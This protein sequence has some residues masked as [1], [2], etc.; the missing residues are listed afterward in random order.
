MLTQINNWLTA[1]TTALDADADLA[2]VV[3]HLGPLVT[4]DDI[5]GAALVIVGHDDDDESGMA[6]E[7]TG[8]W[9]D[10]G[11]A[12]IHRGDA[13]V[14]ITVVSQSGGVGLT[15]AQRMAALSTLVGNVRDVLLPSP[16]GSNL[17]VDGVMW[18]SETGIRQHLIPTAA[19]PIAR[20]VLVFTVAV[21]A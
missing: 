10:T 16:S 20:A 9:H 12:A 3:V 7:F 13:Q 15:M 8:E 2:S 18:A 19:G 1:A 5:T 17:G 21:L 11:G 14:Y 4:F 6:W